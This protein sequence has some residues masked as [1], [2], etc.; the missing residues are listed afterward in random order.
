[1]F[2]FFFFIRC[3]RYALTDDGRMHIVNLKTGSVETSIAA[4]EQVAVMMAAAAAAAAAAVVVVIVVVV[5]LVVMLLGSMHVVQQCSL[6]LNRLQEPLGCAMHPHRNTLATWA[7]DG[8]I[9]LWR[10]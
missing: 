2:D 5:A 4:H 3:F 7:E 10:P 9:K 8:V 1:M 6:L